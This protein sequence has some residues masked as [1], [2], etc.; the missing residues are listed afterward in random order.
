MLY[1]AL[2]FKRLKDTPPNYFYTKGNKRLGRFGF[3]KS[4]LVAKGYDPNKTER[5]IMA[6]LGYD[7]IYDCGNMKFEWKRQEKDD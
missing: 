7:R 6:E 5:Q 1:H 3:R 2:G 4:V